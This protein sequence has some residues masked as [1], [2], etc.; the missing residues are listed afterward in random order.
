MTMVSWPMDQGLQ[1]VTVLIW[2]ELAIFPLLVA[3]IYF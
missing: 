2:V 3:D 1:R